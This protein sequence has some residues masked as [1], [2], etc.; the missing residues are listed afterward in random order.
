MFSLKKKHNSLLENTKEN[1]FINNCRKKEY[2]IE[3]KNTVNIFFCFLR[4][5]NNKQH[6]KLAKKYQKKISHR[7]LTEKVATHFTTTT[8]NKKR[9]KFHSFAI[10]NHTK[11]EKK[12]IYIFTCKFKSSVARGKMALAHAKRHEIFMS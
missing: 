9:Q 5:Q 2:K 12:K 7:L 10:I 6:L 11:N 4:F 1:K 3:I 8:K